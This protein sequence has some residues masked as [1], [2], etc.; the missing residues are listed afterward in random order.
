MTDFAALKALGAITP[1]TFEQ[2][3]VGAGHLGQSLDRYLEH[4]RLAP[5]LSEEIGLHV[6]FVDAGSFRLWTQVWQPAS[7]CGTAFVV[8]GYFDH[9]GLYR[10]LLEL[11]LSRGWQ[12]VLWDLPGHGLS[13][14]PRASIKDFAVY[15]DCLAA[16][17]SH[18]EMQGLAPHPWVG[19]GQS[20]GA[21]IL[22][23]DTLSQGDASRWSGLALLAPLV[24]PWGWSQSSWLHWVA[25]PFIRTLP[26]KFRANSTDADFAEFLRTSDPLQ[27]SHLDV[28]WIS[29]MRRWMPR[30][31]A[32]PAHPLPVLVLQGKQDNTVDWRWNLDVL[33]RKFP[34]ARFHCH[35]EARHHLVNEADTIRRELFAELECYL[36]ELE[37]ATSPNP[38]AIRIMN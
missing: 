15:G 19:I 3:E 18:L 28:A 24:R 12:V 31:L 34:N 22:A 33:Q 13:N 20:T 9:L 30:L 5:L 11:L 38:H 25:S 2:T 1:A 23:T 7:P 6:G 14:G 17:Q 36:A 10:H 27:P 29:A 32:L 8:H 35:P 37:T 4:Y 21:A 26:R 16:L